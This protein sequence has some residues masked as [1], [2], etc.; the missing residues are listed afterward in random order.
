MNV[1]ARMIPTRRHVCGV[2]TVSALL[3]AQMQGLAAAA[4][5]DP[6][7]AALERALVPDTTPEQRYAT[8]RREAYGAFHQ[9]QA[10]C[11]GQPASERKACLREAQQQL[12]LDL[13]AA[14]AARKQPAPE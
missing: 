5:T 8:A 11:Q 3:L 1:F 9:A 13:K 6:D 10:D 12:D 2:L 4:G 7:A 14:L